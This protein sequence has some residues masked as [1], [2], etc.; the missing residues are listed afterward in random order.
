MLEIG[1][2]TT[3]PRRPAPGPALLEPDAPTCDVLE[4]IL[5]P[6]RIATVEPDRRQEVF[7]NPAGLDQVIAAIAAA[8]RAHKPDLSTKKGRDAIA[9]LAFKV[10]KCKTKLDG[11]GKDLVDDL[12]ALPKAIDANRKAMRD[13]LE[14]LQEEVRRP[15]DQWEALQADQARELAR[16]QDLLATHA[17]APIDTI[18]EAMAA[19]CALVI[20]AAWDRRGEILAARDQ[21]LGD[22]DTLL[23]ARRQAEK[24]AAEL[25]RLRA[26]KEA[27]DAEDRRKANEDRIRAEAAEKAK[28]DA[29]EAVARAEREKAEADER[30]RLAEA[31]A[32]REQEDAEARAIDER[33]KA[34]EREEQARIEERQRL[35]R[36]QRAAA[37]AASAR[38]RDK[39]HRRAVNVAAM[40]DLVTNAGLTPEQARAMVIAIAQKA[41]RNVS[42]SY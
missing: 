4:G 16:I 24:D 29:A 13:R 10:A 34:D 11:I 35:E 36:E 31:R 18:A 22:L 15:L 28:R 38:E 39:D 25:A 8:A 5:E 27:R 23:G 17:H 20:P 7:T 14:A 41:V 9:S 40:E 42:I 3:A 12:K 37:D 32:R 19:L 33:R 6:E 26:E 21:A 1:T 30:A 2:A